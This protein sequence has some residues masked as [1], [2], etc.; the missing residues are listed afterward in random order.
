M[1]LEDISKMSDAEL[2]ERYAGKRQIVCGEYS[3][4]SLKDSMIL[5][6]LEDEMIKRGFDE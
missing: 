5:S 4:F 3:C 1:N 6:A 2:K